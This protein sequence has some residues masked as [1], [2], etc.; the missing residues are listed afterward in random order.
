[1][2]ATVTDPELHPRGR[3]WGAHNLP[4]YNLGGGIFSDFTPAPCGR[5]CFGLDYDT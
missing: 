5:T 4:W 3:L 2:G 1:M